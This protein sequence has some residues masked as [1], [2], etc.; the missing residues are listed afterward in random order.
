[1]SSASRGPSIGSIGVLAL[2]VIGGFVVGW[3]TLLVMKCRLLGAAC[4]EIQAQG[5]VDGISTR[6]AK[7]SPMITSG[8]ADQVGWKAVRSG[9]RLFQ[10]SAVVQMVMLVIYFVGLSSLIILGSAGLL[11]METIG[12]TARDSLMEVVLLGLVAL[13]ILAVLA[14]AVL[15]L[16]GAIYWLQVPP[17]TGCKSFVVIMLVCNFLVLASPGLAYAGGAIQ[18]LALQ[19]ASHLL[20]HSAALIATVMLLVSLHS[21]GSHLQSSELRKQV[22]RYLIM[23]GVFFGTAVLALF[24]LVGSYALG[25]AAA[26]ALATSILVL[27]VASVVLVVGWLVVLDM[28]YRLFR[29]AREGDPGPGAEGLTTLTCFFA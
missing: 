25:L 23:L 26:T 14:M 16:I 20:G 24:V 17:N 13:A 28:K 9:L 19:W 12:P 22:M 15:D 1:M 6:T 21:I 4:N 8:D 27:A 10:I 11:P 5:F 29:A 2:I 18:S 7:A 3:L